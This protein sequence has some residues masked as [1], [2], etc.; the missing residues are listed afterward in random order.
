MVVKPALGVTVKVVVAP[1]FT[2]CEAGAIVPPA[3][4]VAVTVKVIGA[5]VA[6]T[7]Q[8]ATIAPVV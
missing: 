8:F 5:K 4:A 2:I 3:P 6:D 7:E 1:L